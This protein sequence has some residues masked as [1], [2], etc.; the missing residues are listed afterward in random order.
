MEIEV[1]PG[2]ML[3]VGPASP[4]LWT[5]VTL[6][7]RPVQLLLSCGPEPSF[8]QDPNPGNLALIGVPQEH[9]VRSGGGSV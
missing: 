3:R 2:A 1:G 4:R 5:L 6:P 9:S 8:G 7:E